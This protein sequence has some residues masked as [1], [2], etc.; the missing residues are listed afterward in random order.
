MRVEFGNTAPTAT[1]NSPV[2]TTIVIPDSYGYTAHESAATLAANIARHLATAP[3]GITRLGDISDGTGDHEAILATIT[4]VRNE[5]NATPAWVWS[6]N[7]DFAVLVGEFYGCPVG[8]PDDTEDTHFTASGAPGVHPEDL[9]PDEPA[10][11]P[12]PAPEA[13][14]TEATE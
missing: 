2:V 3:G 12:F 7:E 14:A 8:R 10:I 13:D 9:V 6:D 11:D 1:E 4:G 5:S